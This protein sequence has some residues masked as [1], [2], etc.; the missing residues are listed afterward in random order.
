MASKYLKDTK[1]NID[2]VL[3]MTGNFNLRDS[4]WN[5]LFSNHSIHSELLMDIANSLNLSIY[6]PTFQVSIK[7]AN[8]QNNL[9]SII[10]LMFLQFT[11]DKFDN[12]VIHPEWRLSLDHAP[13]TVKISILEEYI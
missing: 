13:L 8:N 3:I 9:N 6:S 5:S 2:N 1:A 11:S 4:S 12:H 7:Y 10:N